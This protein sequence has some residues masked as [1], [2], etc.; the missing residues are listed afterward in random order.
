M[1]RSAFNMGVS[2]MLAMGDRISV[3]GNNIANSRTTAFKA[4][5]LSFAEEFV[6][7]SGTL[8]NG[9][10]LQ[11]GNGVRTGGTTTDWSAGSIEGTSNPANLAI[12]GDGFFPVLYED[13]IFFTRAGDF[14]LVADNPSNPAYFY[15]Q[16]PNGAVL[17]GAATAGGAVTTSTI[18]KFA[19]GD[20]PTPAPTSYS[21]SASGVVSAL[22][23]SLSP[24]SPVAGD[25]GMPAAG[26]NDWA[27]LTLAEHTTYAAWAAA[28]TP[29]AYDPGWDGVGLVTNTWQPVEDGYAGA[30]KAITVSAG[31]I[32]VQRFNNPDSLERVQ[33]GM[34]KATSA[35]SKVSEEPS[36]P[37]ADGTGTLMQGSLENSNTDLITEFTDM[38]ITQRAF[39]ANSKTITTAD[40]MLQTVLALKN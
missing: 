17:L 4:S 26:G 37:G 33:G 13:N 16:R 39:Q 24:A 20:T 34:Y 10:Q 11:F 29:S 15:F 6:T 1:A 31:F 30:H 28:Q 35:T 21:I 14:A 23:N 3:I 19:T 22:P 5:K 32:G 38:I 2:G 18:L 25:P 40:E 9:L 8:P 12:T 7:H 27:A 36:V